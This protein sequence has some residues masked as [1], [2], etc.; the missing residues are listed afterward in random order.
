MEY[1]DY[2][3]ITGAELDLEAPWMYV[4]ISL[5]GSPTSGPD[6]YYGVEIDLDIDGRGD[7]FIY[8]MS[9][10]STDWTTVGVFAHMDLDDDV[11]G[12]VPVRAD[13]GIAGDDGYDEL[14]FDEGRGDD[15]D[16]AWIR[17][18]PD[19]PNSV[20]LAFKHSLIESDAYFMWGVWSDEG[21]HD[22]SMLDYN[23]EFTIAEAGS[24]SIS[25]EHYPI[26]ALYLMDNSCRWGYGFEPDGTE[27]GVCYI[28]PTA[29]VPPPTV[30]PPTWTPIPPGSITI[31][32]YKDLN[33]SGSWDAGDLHYVGVSVTLG[34][35]S[36]NSSGYASGV[37]NGIGRV[38]F[39][40]LAPGP[41]CVITYGT[42][43]CMDPWIPITSDRVTVN[44]EAGEMHFRRIGYDTYPC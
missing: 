13:A 11:G 33:G 21:L 40:N 8:G 37:T 17:L 18:N 2:L 30:V 22:M 1:R 38:T 24:P 23:D 15:P 7:W 27:P 32:V 20:Q 14:V 44:V 36:C 29:T 3:D 10:P 28:P 42:T 34:Q 39:N 35:G 19:D 25:S 43:P 41:Y 5:E 16:A 9:P 12:S 6:A 26:L 31:H 4:T